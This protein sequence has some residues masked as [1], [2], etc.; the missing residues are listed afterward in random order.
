MK[1]PEFIESVIAGDFRGVDAE[2]LR[3][4]GLGTGHLSAWRERDI[5]RPQVAT[6]QKVE[7]AIGARITIDQDGEVSA[8]DFGQSDPHI[9]PT[10]PTGGA[11]R[12][13]E[14]GYAAD[15]LT[16]AHMI[17]MYEQV[18]RRTDCPRWEDLS[19]EL[20]SRVKLAWMRYESRVARARADLTEAVVEIL[21]QDVR[22]R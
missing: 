20:R 12:E 17:E 22:Q 8:L 18:A 9:P 19:E 7:Q 11:A 15:A 2:F 6:I 14:T 4:T 10:V 3:A 21:Q 13:P 1:W 16:E 5:R